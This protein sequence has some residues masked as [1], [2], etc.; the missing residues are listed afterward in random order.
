MKKI[1]LI[2]ILSCNSLLFSKAYFTFNGTYSHFLALRSSNN[3]ILNI[4]FRLFNLDSKMIIDDFE[5]YSNFSLEFK[6]EYDD[7]F[8]T[9]N[10][11]FE[12]RELYA[13]YFFN[14]G[15]ISFGK[16]MFSL[17]SVDEN[18]PIDHFNPYNYYY[19]LT[20]GKDK[21]IGV[22]C[23]SFDLYFEDIRIT[24]AISPF[25]NLN[26]YPKDDPEY[27]LSL[28]INPSKY[29]IIDIRGS[30]HESLFSIQKSLNNSEITLSYLRAYDRVFSLS[31]FAI[32]ESTIFDSSGSN[33]PDLIDIKY[34]YRLTEAINLGTIFL[35]NDFTIR[36]DLA[37][38]HSFDRN[39]KNDYLNLTS[40]IDAQLYDIDPNYNPNTPF[41]GVFY[42][43]GD[44]NDDGIN[45]IYALP[46]R[47]D[48]YFSQFTL[49]FEMPLPKDFQ[50]NIQYF[51]HR[52]HNYSVVNYNLT[53]INLPMAEVSTG[54]FFV[55][56]FGSSMSTLTSESILLSLEKQ[57]LENNLK[58]SITSFLDLDK[59][60]GKLY[61][62]E[63]EYDILDNLDFTFGITKVIGDDSVIPQG[64]YD[65]G[66]TFNLMEDFSHKRIQL[67]Y[68]F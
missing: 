57:L 17:G 32:F 36:T 67:N 5:I 15:E 26:H 58:C 42:D 45:D 46:L 62:L 12:N 47:E 64:S 39:N 22:H 60:D 37:Y 53:T 8:H 38:F 66:Y 6:K 20:G 31:G 63:I 14:Q 40:S 43:N 51:L 48:V 2:L 9:K 27:Q 33:G 56:G 19:L 68:H 61:S 11:E 10:I 55:P 59:G 29:D 52:L 30:K 65:M 24:A 7:Y 21:K 28:P 23:F 50:L 18:S 41:Y 3:E 13:T 4:P 16:K 44:L 1:I 34:S 49:Q 25:H 54:T 35:F